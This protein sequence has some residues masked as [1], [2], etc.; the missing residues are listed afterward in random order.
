MRCHGREVACAHGASPLLPRF[1]AKQG[2]QTSLSLEAVN[3]NAES[4]R[5]LLPSHE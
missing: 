5:N 2:R 4:G 1:N 3:E